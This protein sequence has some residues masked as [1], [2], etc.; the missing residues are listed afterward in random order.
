MWDIKGVVSKGDYIYAIVHEHPNAIDHGYVLYHRVLMENKIGR[1]LK[2]HEIVHHINENKRD[3]RL[4]NLEL[5]NYRDHIKNHSFKQGKQY[6]ELKCPSCNKNFNKDRNHSHLAR[7]GIYTVCSQKCKGTFSRKIQLFGYTEEINKQILTN[8]IREYKIFKNFPINDIVNKL[9]IIED[10]INKINSELGYVFKPI[11]KIC[12]ICKKEFAPINKRIKYCSVECM[13]I[14]SRRCVRPS[15]EILKKLI[16]TM[17]M[18]A[19]GRKFSVSGNS[20]K[21]W[22]IIYK[23]L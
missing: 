18:E 7:K 5:M 6:V 14:A 4:E 21:K 10:D 11:I 13:G 1:V 8:V 20:I 3:N 16:D 17:S 22:A 19:I 2:N 15:A 23:I 9:P 12:S